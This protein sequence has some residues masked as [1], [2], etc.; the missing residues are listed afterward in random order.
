MTPKR[1]A[2]FLYRKD[3]PAGGWHDLGASRDTPQQARR[4]ADDYLGNT[5]ASGGRD[6][7]RSSAPEA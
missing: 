3:N 5:T 1:F 4:V 2:V 6:L 7:E